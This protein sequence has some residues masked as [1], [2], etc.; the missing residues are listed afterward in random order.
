MGGGEEERR[1]GMPVAA[2][3]F[4]I[5]IPVGAALLAVHGLAPVAAPILAVRGSAPVVA[6]LL[7]IR[8]VARDRPC[9]HGARQWRWR[10][11]GL[12]GASCWERTV[13]HSYDE[14]QYIPMALGMGAFRLPSPS[15]A[16]G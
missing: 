12:R 14:Q 6:A 8:G 9:E 10:R 3:L 2:G 5:R 1:E 15:G 4:A 11:Q 7:V 13:R 16:V